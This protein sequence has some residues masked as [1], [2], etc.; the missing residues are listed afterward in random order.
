MKSK[1]INWTLIGLMAFLTACGGSDTEG[2]ASGGTSTGGTNNDDDNNNDPVADVNTDSIGLGTGT[3]TSYVDGQAEIGVGSNAL[4]ANGQTTVKVSIVNLDDSNSA[5]L[6]LSNVFFVSACSQV[7]L[8]EFSPSEVQASGEAS[9]TYTDK[10]CGRE[11]GSDDSIVV[12]VGT[13]DDEGN[14][15]PDA[16]ARATIT[17]APAKVGAMQ[18]VNAEPSLIAINGYG[19]EDTPS[20]TQVQFKLVDVSGTAMPERTVNF[21]LDHEIGNAA[22]SLT[23]AVTNQDGLASV[24]LNAGNSPGTVRVRASIDVD[25]GGTTRTIETMSAPIVMAT[26]LGD[27]NSFSLSTSSFN[28]YA[29]DFNGTEVNITAHLGD[30]SQNP[31]L[32]GTRI[33][34]TATGGIIQPSCET[35]GGSCSVTW[36]SANPRPVDGYVKIVAHTRGQGDYQDANSN[37]LFDTTED[38]DTY[39]ETWIDANGNGVYDEDQLYQPDLDIDNDGGNEFAWSATAVNFYEE[40]I[41]SNFNGAHDLNGGAFY[42]GANCSDAAETAGHCASLIDVSASLTLQMSAGSTINIEG[43]F[44]WSDGLGRYDTS[45]VIDCVNVDSATHRVGW[46][47]SDSIARRNALPAGSKIGSAADVAKISAQSGTGEV[48]S[49]SP[50]SVLP[51][52]EAN[53][54]LT[55]AALKYDYLAAR[56]HIVEF[57]VTKPESFTVP[58][59]GHGSLAPSVELANGDTVIGTA[60]K[61]DVTNTVC[62]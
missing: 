57:W 50:P 60:V 37:G 36:T 23:S 19:T 13:K 58:A 56:G 4:A 21:A 14:I 31:V 40:F 9:S 39:G 52:Y 30:H 28:P 29:W 48:S 46:R 18:F 45:T 34:F 49:I 5:Y 55:G 7:G 32:D 47:I 24:I 62:P 22:L 26:S 16:T 3:G 33:Y 17:V 20:L 35:Q 42:Q 38:F 51:V 6:G 8:A 25:D 53:S 12:F 1:I 61:V 59:S 27:Q 11:S 44:A 10:G 41:D 43:P 15:I 54:V 2:T